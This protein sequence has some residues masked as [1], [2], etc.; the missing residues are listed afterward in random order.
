MLNIEEIIL[1]LKSLIEQLIAQFRE[2]I[3]GIRLSNEPTTP[4][5]PE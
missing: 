4:G 1:T 3:A 2:L 5:T